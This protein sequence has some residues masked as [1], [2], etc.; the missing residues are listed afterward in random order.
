M[1][2]Q[3]REL[4]RC[5]N[6]AIQEMLDY[7][8]EHTA[9]LSGNIDKQNL[10]QVGLAFRAGAVNGLARAV[11][12]FRHYKSGEAPSGHAAL[13]DFC[14]AFIEQQGFGSAECVAQNDIDY[15]DLVGFVTGICEIVG[16]IKHSEE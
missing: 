5:R 15:A 14:E 16:Y 9:V 12:I 8:D 1:E 2:K 4:H 6:A 3:V 7:K 10:P 11:Q 13:W